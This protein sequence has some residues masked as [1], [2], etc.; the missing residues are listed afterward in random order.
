MNPATAPHPF[1]FPLSPR[2]PRHD[3]LVIQDAI[4]EVLRLA[5]YGSLR[6]IQVECAGDAVTL[7]GRVPTY[8]LKQLAQNVVLDVPGIDIVRNELHVC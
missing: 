1:E 7:S 8:Y 5:G 3:S 4:Q 6:C 2:S